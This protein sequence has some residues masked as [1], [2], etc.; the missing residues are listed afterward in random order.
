MHEQQ[1]TVRTRPFKLNYNDEIVVKVGSAV[2][3]S[4]SR[5][6]KGF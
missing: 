2:L 1:A 4:G 5:S 3:M 6:E